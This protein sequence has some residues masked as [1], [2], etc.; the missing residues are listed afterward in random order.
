MNWRELEKINILPG[1]VPVVPPSIMTCLGSN[2]T[3]PPWGPVTHVKLS[4][5]AYRRC[6]STRTPLFLVTVTTASLNR[7]PALVLGVGRCYS[8]VQ[9]YDVSLR[10]ILQRLF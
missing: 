5:I 7:F 4:C 3:S 2:H 9:E 6:Y 10:T 8:T 1:Q